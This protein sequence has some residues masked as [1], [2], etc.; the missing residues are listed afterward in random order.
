MKKLLT[1]I[2]STL[3][4][5]GTAFSFSCGVGSSNGSLTFYCPD[6]APALAIAKCINDNENF[7]TLETLVEKEI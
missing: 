3:M 4:I 7:G 5:I 1:I 2:L 6:G